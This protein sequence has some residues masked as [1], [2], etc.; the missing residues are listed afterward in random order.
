MQS[1]E[2]R[3][4]PYQSKDTSPTIPTYR[5]KEVNGK[6]VDLEDKNRTNSLGQ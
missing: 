1:C 3:F 4:A 6:T 2:E 5:K